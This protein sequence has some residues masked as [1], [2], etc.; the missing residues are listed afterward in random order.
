MSNK[1]EKIILND[2]Y[3]MLKMKERGVDLFFTDIDRIL[4]ML[5]EDEKIKM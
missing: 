1:L 5:E 2:F 4:S 3:S